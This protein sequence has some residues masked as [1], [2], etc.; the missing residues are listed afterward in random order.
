MIDVD[1]S[2]TYV[3]FDL[4]PNHDTLWEEYEAIIGPSET[5][6]K[7]RDSVQLYKVADRARKFLRWLGT[8]PEQHVIVCSHPFFLRVLLND[9]LDTGRTPV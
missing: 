4:V 5:H 3:Q 6:A 8:R 2:S 7:E 9:G 1:L